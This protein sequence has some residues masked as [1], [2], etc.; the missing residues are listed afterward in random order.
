MEK[1]SEYVHIKKTIE[2]SICS[3]VVRTRDVVY[4]VVYDLAGAYLQHG[5][6][7]QCDQREVFG[8]EK[9]KGSP[10]LFGWEASL[11]CCATLE[12]SL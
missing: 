3:T 1:S 10:F 12:F 9:E 8:M 7:L 2:V 11:P 5:E 4:V 6:V